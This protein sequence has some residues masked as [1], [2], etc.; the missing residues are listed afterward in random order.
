MV[1]FLR[2]QFW[3]YQ[4]MVISESGWHGA[5]LPCMACSLGH[6]F[7]ADCTAK[8]VSCE[9]SID[10]LQDSIWAVSGNCVSLIVTQE[11]AWENFLHS[12]NA[13]FL[14]IH[15]SPSLAFQ[16]TKIKH[17]WIPEQGAKIDSKR[18]LHF[19]CNLAILDLSLEILC[20]VHYVLIRLALICSS[21][22]LGRISTVG[23]C[24]LSEWNLLYFRKSAN[25]RF[26]FVLI[27]K[28]MPALLNLCVFSSA[29]PRP[30]R[31][32]LKRVC[33][34]FSLWVPHQKNMMFLWNQPVFMQMKWFLLKMSSLSQ[35]CAPAFCL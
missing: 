23:M 33:C 24:L 6:W 16:K 21:S 7:L 27:L 13:L 34:V 22:K 26:S 12:Q 4:E 15:S 11:A 32:H 31:H 9:L 25:C 1:T 19:C 30:C 5:I 28:T 2:D 18:I 10:L 3:E 35:E 20:A 14:L 29:K 17:L 8:V